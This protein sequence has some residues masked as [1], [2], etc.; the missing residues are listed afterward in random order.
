MLVFKSLSIIGQCP[1]S[2]D[3]QATKVGAIEMGLQATK[4]GAIEMG[5]STQNG[6]VFRSKLIKFQ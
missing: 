5:L 6:N 2:I 3:I 4:V 1:V